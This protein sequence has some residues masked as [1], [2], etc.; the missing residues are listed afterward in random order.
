MRRLVTKHPVL[1]ASFGILIVYI[2]LYAFI[3]S[4]VYRTLPYRAAP[5]KINLNQQ[6]RDLFGTLLKPDSYFHTSLSGLRGDEPHPDIVLLN[7]DNDVIAEQNTWPIARTV[8]ARIFDRLAEAGPEVVLVDMLFEWP[9]SPWVLDALGRHIDKIPQDTYLS[10]I[11]EL[12]F[13]GQLK[14]SLAGLDYVLIY[15]LAR[16]SEFVAGSQRKRYAANMARI[17]R[18][19]GFTMEVEGT[20]EQELYPYQRIHG[21]RTCIV[22]LQLR[23]KGQG[24]AWLNTDR[25]G[26]V[27]HVPLF[28]RLQTKSD[29]P[30]SYYLANAIAETARVAAGA[31]KYRLR[32]HNGEATGLDVGGHAIKTDPAAEMQINFYDR[33]YTPRIPVIRAYDLLNGEVSKE[34]LENKV[35]IFGSDTNLL[36]DYHDTPV[37]QVWG[38]EILAYAISNILN[39]D[40]LYKPRWAPWLEIPMLVL[41]FAGVMWS[42]TRLRPVAALATVLALGAGAAALVG[43]LFVKWGQTFSV[44]IPLSLVG[45]LYIQSTTMRFVIDERQKRLYKNALGLYLSPQLTEQV[46]DNPALLSLEGK[47]QE[48]TVL[49]SDIRGFTSISENMEP[50]ELTFFLHQYLSPMTDIVFDTEGTLDKYIGDAVMAFWGAPLEQPD[51]ARRACEAALRM[52]EKLDALREDWIAAGLPPIQIGVG[53]NTGPMRVG[54]MG[55][56][57]RLSYT[58]MGDNV[59]LGSR[60]EGLTKH[61]G[62]RLIASQ[63]TWKQIRSAFYGRELDR[64]RVKGKERAIPIYEVR[65]RGAPPGKEAE[66]LALWEQ[67]LRAYRDR[68]WDEAETAFRRWQARFDDRTAAL[69]LEQIE[70]YRRDPP[71]EDWE[72]VSVMSS[73]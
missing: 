16:H 58:V 44:T 25:Y 28:H 42:V 67:G 14:K 31:K 71:P 3:E 51:H 57:R 6:A 8:H 61:Y 23:A 41:L 48:L 52:L 47:E 70:E 34:Q 7:L 32:I 56:D 13:D 37:G 62:V 55:S 45:L 19:P 22:P 64:V 2:A 35:I 60:L 69:Y 46:A 11:R 30:E 43:I 33:R 5:A 63:T 68:L 54:N 1:S 24:F 50:E 27:G 39:G 20:G 59:N 29:P 36:H 53:L 40:Y 12:N 66:H 72:P 65:G 49:F 38:T 9:Q 26:T 73:K 21:V 17:A 4:W 10:L 15:A 18:Q